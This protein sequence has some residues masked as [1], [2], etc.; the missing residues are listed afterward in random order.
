M[1]R[2]VPRRLHRILFRY[3][4]TRGL[5]VRAQALVTEIILTLVLH[6]LHIGVKFGCMAGEGKGSNGLGRVTV[7]EGN[8]QA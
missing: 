1:E 2:L 5:A 6:V 3:S 7:W 8:P 4:L